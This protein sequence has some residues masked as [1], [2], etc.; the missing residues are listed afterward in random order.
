MKRLLAASFALAALAGCPSSGDVCSQLTVFSVKNGACLQ[1]TF[2]PGQSECEASLSRCSSAQANALNSY[3]TCLNALPACP[4]GATLSEQ[5]SWAAQMAACGSP[6]S[7][8]ACL[9]GTSSGGTS[10]S[11]S[12]GSTGGGSSSGGSTGGPSCAV[13]QGS[14]TTLPCCSGSCQQGLCICTPGGGNCQGGRD[15]CS[16]VC[17]AG[18]C[19]QCNDVGSTCQ[20]NANCCSGSCVNGACVAP[21]TSLGV[22]QYTCL[23]GAPPPTLPGSLP[24]GSVCISYADCAAACSP[25]PGNGPEF[26]FAEC[27]AG[28]CAATVQAYDDALATNPSFCFVGGTSGGATGGGSSGGSSGGT[29]GP[30]TTT[31][32]DGL[33]ATDGTGDT[34]YLQDF[35]FKTELTTEGCYAT[36]STLADGAALSGVGGVYSLDVDDNGAGATP[37]PALYVATCSDL[38][39]AG[40]PTV[41][42]AYT[43]PA[44]GFTS[45]AQA[46]AARPTGVTS[47]WGVVTAS[48]PWQQTPT[49]KSGWFYI[50]DPVAGG[51]A[52]PGSGVEVFLPEGG[53]TLIN[54]SYGYEPAL[55]D[56]VTV[57]NVLWG[58]YEGAN[59]F[60]GQTTTAVAKIGTTPLPPPVQLSPA[61]VSTTSSPGTSAYQDMRVTVA[62]TF[63]AQGTAASSDC[64]TPLTETVTSP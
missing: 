24:Q 8:L 5:A 30:V 29:T 43:A 17:S 25:C 41:A 63:T 35:D 38:G 37:A 61:Q 44:S 22:A 26:W 11:T 57:T 10:G 16:A 27:A 18:V 39:Y 14:C 62:S 4:A 32:C 50:Q 12:G 20:T 2:L 19:A 60:T 7:A 21:Q 51:G 58:T 28:K 6:G 31:Y 13:G 3:V 52:P 48:K 59:Q 64:P 9:G 34:V 36:V 54:Q 49:L 42:N 46:V 23:A 55:G 45:V 1:S 33:G 40:S 47:F 56:V 15:C 53:A